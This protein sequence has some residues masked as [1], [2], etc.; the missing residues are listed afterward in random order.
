MSFEECHSKS[1][2]ALKLRFTLQSTYIMVIQKENLI[3]FHLTGIY[4][5]NDMKI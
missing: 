2:M 4:S 3:I 5:K 1:D